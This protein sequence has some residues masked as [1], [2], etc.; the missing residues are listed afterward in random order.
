[1]EEGAWP[2]G[3][4]QLILAHQ[5]AAALHQKLQKFERASAQFYGAPVEKK[6]LPARNESKW[7]EGEY[8]FLSACALLRCLR[9]SPH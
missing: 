2:G 6:Q 3:G 7:A 1:M 9:G 8:E 5:F 4:H